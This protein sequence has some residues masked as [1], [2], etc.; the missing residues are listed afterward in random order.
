MEVKEMAD[1]IKDWDFTQTIGKYCEITTCQT[2]AE[3]IIRVG[4]HLYFICHKHF[5]E[6]SAINRSLRGESKI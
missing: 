5:K 3:M 4:E 1:T 6:C 2:Q